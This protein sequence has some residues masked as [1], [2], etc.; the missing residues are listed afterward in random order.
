MCCTAVLT[1]LDIGSVPPGSNSFQTMSRNDRQKILPHAALY[2]GNEEIRMYLLDNG[3]EESLDT[4]NH[5]PRKSYG[6]KVGESF[7]LHLATRYGDIN[8]V[9]TL[10][11]RGAK[12]LQD[13]DGKTP[14]LVTEE[15][16]Q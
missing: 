4:P 3:L 8:M 2:P 5:S 6:F 16:T 14:L 15:N 1:S 12:M 10:L 9:K 11:D 13:E 7:L